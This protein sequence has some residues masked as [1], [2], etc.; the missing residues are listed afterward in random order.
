MIR[1]VDKIHEGDYLRDQQDRY[2][3]VKRVSVASMPAMIVIQPLHDPEANGVA[4]F[5]LSQLA[6]SRLS[7]APPAMRSG[8]NYE[9]HQGRRRQWR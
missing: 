2:F 6:D 3:R 5:K 4:I 1:D 9:S 7:A 8:P